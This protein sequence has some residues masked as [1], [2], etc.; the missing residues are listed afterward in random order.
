MLQQC[1]HA[2]AP[3]FWVAPT[4]VQLV[5]FFGSGISFCGFLESSNLLCLSF[6]SDFYFAGILYFRARDLPRKLNI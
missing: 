2:S 6:N 4:V 5:G 3:A 1:P